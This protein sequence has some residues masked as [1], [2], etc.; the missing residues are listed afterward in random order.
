MRQLLYI[1]T[2][3]PDA[4]ATL[5]ADGILTISRRNNVLVGVTGLLFFDGKRF[6]QA[7][8]GSDDAVAA[9]FARIQRDPRHRG[10]VTLSDR[11]IAVREF[12][13]WAM[14][15]YRPDEDRGATMDR[16]AACVANAAP[17]V[18]ATFDGFADIRRAA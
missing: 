7:L 2:V 14:A 9:T 10:V 4:A 8:E 5:D 15:Q 1:S 16:I 12:G 11:T 3:H 13:D 17:A 18:R 6:L